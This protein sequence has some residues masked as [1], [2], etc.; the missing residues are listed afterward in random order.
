VLADI[1]D[2]MLVNHHLTVSIAVLILLPQ[3]LILW[4]FL[5]APS[6]SFRSCALWEPSGEL[7]F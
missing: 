2:E 6:E 3:V 7:S 1:Q 5:G 4:L